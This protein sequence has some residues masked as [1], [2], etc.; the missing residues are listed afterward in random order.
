MGRGEFSRPEII[1]EFLYLKK[2]ISSFISIVRESRPTHLDISSSVRKPRL[3]LV[4][5]WPSVR[6]PRHTYRV[7]VSKPSAPQSRHRRAR[8]KQQVFHNVEEEEPYTQ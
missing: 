5:F 3:Y 8:D 7:V 2:K 4:I 1:Y 6:K